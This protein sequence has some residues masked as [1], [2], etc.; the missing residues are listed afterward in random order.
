MDRQ[1]N[2][3]GASNQDMIRAVTSIIVNSVMSRRIVDMPKIDPEQHSEHIEAQIVLGMFGGPCPD[4][5]ELE[6]LK[7]KVASDQPT[8]YRSI[9]SIYA[10]VLTKFKKVTG[11]DAIHDRLQLSDRAVLWQLAVERASKVYAR[12]K[13]ASNRRRE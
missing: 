6:G 12:P 11:K 10:E 1:F 2:I 5:A 8:Y 9:I 7:V 4:R 3:V 13:P